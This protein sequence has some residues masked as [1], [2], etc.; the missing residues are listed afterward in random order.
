MMRW[1]CVKNCGA[2]C[3]LDPSERP[4]LDDYLD[5]E[6][7]A[8]YLS[9]VAEDGWCVHFDPQTRECRIYDERPEFCR[10]RPDTFKQMF[11]V[12]EDEFEEFAI[13]CCI[14]QIEDLYGEDSPEM[15]RYQ[16]SV[17]F[18]SSN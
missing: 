16:E 8:L 11:D 15:Q 13:A 18:R 4:E 10:V 7:L 12:E 3:Y 1:C 2:C 17:D 9:M 14:E 6:A 5:P